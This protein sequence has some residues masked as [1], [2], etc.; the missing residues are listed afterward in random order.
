MPPFGLP[1]LSS[2]PV[3]YLPLWLGTLRDYSGN[4]NHSVN[5]NGCWRE[6]GYFDGFDP[7]NSSGV[8]TVGDSPELQLTKLTIFTS[9]KQLGNFLPHPGAV[10]WVIKRDATGINWD[11]YID[12]GGGRMVFYD[13]V[14][15]RVRNAN[16]V[17]SSSI[18]VV[19]SNSEVPKLYIDG[20]FD[21]LFNGPVAL[22]I[23]DSPI[24][25]GRTHFTNPQF[26]GLISCVL[27]YNVELAPEEI[28]SLYDW[29]QTLKTPRK[30]WPGCVS[31]PGRPPLQTGDP[32]YVDNISSARVSLKDETAG[33]LSNTTFTIQSGT[34]REKEDAN[35][36]FVECLSAGQITDQVLGASSATT[37]KF[38]YTGTASLTKTNSQ[39]KIDASTGARIT[40]IELAAA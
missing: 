8:L 20:S 17:N 7:C 31:L 6:H 12:T 28:S 3:L 33:T 19:A 34:W 39:I 23:D 9:H 25:I 30:Q 29:S 36:R 40:A 5:T 2:D 35:G 10:R 15:F 22:T 21:G 1:K 37:K 14:T 24:S 18:A 26:P 13:G 38:E 4:N 11:T 32:V 16:F 27:V